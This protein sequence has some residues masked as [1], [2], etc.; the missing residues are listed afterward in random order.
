MYSTPHYLKEKD[1]L[2]P[3]IQKIKKDK[4]KPVFYRKGRVVISQQ[5][6]V[7]HELINEFMLKNELKPVNTIPDFE[8]SKLKLGDRVRNYSAPAGAVSNTVI[9]MVIGMCHCPQIMC[10]KDGKGK[11]GAVAHQ[12]GECLTQIEE[13][14]E[15]EDELAPDPSFDLEL[16]VKIT[17]LKNNPY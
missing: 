12:E 11:A 3:L 5:G 15:V 13:S 1:Q 14:P 17:D 9:F 10:M 6:P 2:W 8:L 4:G 16:N 7:D